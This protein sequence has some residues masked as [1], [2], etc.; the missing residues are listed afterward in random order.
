MGPQTDPSTLAIEMCTWVIC[1]L[2]LP[3][4]ERTII[5]YLAPSELFCWK[6]TKHVGLYDCS[7]KCG[8][9]HTAGIVC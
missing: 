3:S 8:C 4:L 9:V 6:G 7:V 1:F 2:S 5:S